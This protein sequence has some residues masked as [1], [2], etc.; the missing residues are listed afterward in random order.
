MLDFP[1]N[2][3]EVTI[4][5]LRKTCAVECR[6][7]LGWFV[8]PKLGEKARYADYEVLQGKGLLGVNECSVKNKTKIHGIECFEIASS[9]FNIN[10]DRQYH[11]TSYCRIID[12]HVQSLAYCEEYPDG[13]KDFYTFKDKHFMDHWAEGEN[14]SGMDVSLRTK[15]IISHDGDT[16]HTPSFQNGINDIVGEYRVLIGDRE[17]HCARL[18]LVAAEDQVSDFFIDHT[19]KELF[20]RFFIPNDGFK[21]SMKDQSYVS[22][23]PDAY[24]I[25]FNDKICVLSSLILPDY[26]L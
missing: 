21:G 3:P 14:N 16:F 23:F 13:T 17:H 11:V 12:G 20:H 7:V 19:G 25:R 2:V 24:S 10:D 22:K 26:I 8:E 1:K 18:M 15:G 9:Y 6:Q 4:T 5:E